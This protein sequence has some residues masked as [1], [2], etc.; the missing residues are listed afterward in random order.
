MI[1][2]Y[3]KDGVPLKTIFGVAAD[4][5]GKAMLVAICAPSIAIAYYLTTKFAEPTT[6]TEFTNGQLVK[7]TV[8][9]GSEA[10]FI[11]IVVGLATFFLLCFVVGGSLKLY[12]RSIGYRQIPPKYYAR[13]G[14]RGFYR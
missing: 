8:H 13:P 14:S 12:L 9:P 11:P 7:V 10:A 6:H 1:L 3:E 2:N 4:K 5:I